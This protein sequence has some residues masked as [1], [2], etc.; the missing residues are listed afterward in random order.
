MDFCCCRDEFK[1]DKQAGTWWLMPLTP[2]P[3]G[4]KQVDLYE[5]EAS[6]KVENYKVR[7]YLKKENNKKE[8]E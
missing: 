2:T 4:Q 8:M 5:F 3:R 1:K 6:L 7:Y